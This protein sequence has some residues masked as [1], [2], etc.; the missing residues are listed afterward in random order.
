METDFVLILFCS[1]QGGS[2][3]MIVEHLFDQKKIGP[4]VVELN[5]EN[6]VHLVEDSG[7]VDDIFDYAN[8]NLEKVIE[9]AS[10]RLRKKIS[11]SKLCT[12]LPTLFIFTLS[13]DTQINIRLLNC[14]YAETNKH[15]HR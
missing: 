5:P 8:K 3:S 4:L 2:I 10:G 1:Q 15:K 11:K 6:F 13:C 7:D 12:C 9:Y 14:E